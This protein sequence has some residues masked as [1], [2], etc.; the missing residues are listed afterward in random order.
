MWLVHE[1]MVVRDLTHLSVSL[2]LD[3]TVIL[4]VLLLLF[5]RQTSDRYSR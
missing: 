1:L 2:V 3:P 5:A 4:V